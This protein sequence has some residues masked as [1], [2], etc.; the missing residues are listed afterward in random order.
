MY[1]QSKYLPQQ[2]VGCIF[3]S[4]C[5]IYVCIIII[6]SAQ[7]CYLY[8]NYLFF[9][10][11]WFDPYAPL[12]VWCCVPHLSPVSLHIC[13]P[14]WETA[15]IC[16][17]SPATICIWHYIYMNT[18]PEQWQCFHTQQWYIYIGNVIRCVIEK[19]KVD[20]FTD[21]LKNY[22]YLVLHVVLV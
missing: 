11:N 4:I 1:W 14:F 12:S 10:G 8:K 20:M 7:S 9:S 21:T 17:S 16:R 13:H 2:P 3:G 15:G 19:S 6:L 22:Y 5:L 18:L